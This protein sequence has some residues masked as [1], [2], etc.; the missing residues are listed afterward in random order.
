MRTTDNKIQA[1]NTTPIIPDS[2]VQLDCPSS[3]S[4]TFLVMSK[5]VV[6]KVKEKL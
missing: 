2:G 5:K 1:A 6:I 3:H 4:G